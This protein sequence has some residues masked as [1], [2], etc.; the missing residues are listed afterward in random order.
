MKIKIPNIV[1]FVASVIVYLLL[2]NVD[3][4]GNEVL[5]GALLAGIISSLNIKRF[6][7]A[8][9]ASALVIAAAYIAILLSYYA[10]N[11]YGF[12]MMLKS[13]WLLYIPNLVS[14]IVAMLGGALTI[15]AKEYLKTLH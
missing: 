10:T 4:F 15:A 8:I 2:L 7:F 6:R 9:I 1:L 5:I 12:S 13:G 11:P 14:E 3:L